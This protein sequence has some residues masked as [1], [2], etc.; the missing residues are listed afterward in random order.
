MRRAVCIFYFRVSIVSS[1]GG[2]V[3]CG[4]DSTCAAKSDLPFACAE[5][6]I[7]VRW[8]F[9]AR[10]GI[11]EEFDVGGCSFDGGESPAGKLLC[12]DS[13]PPF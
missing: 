1:R 8:V 4:D 11:P 3:S 2:N 10:D 12:G 6:G 13:R 5:G 9:V 7:C